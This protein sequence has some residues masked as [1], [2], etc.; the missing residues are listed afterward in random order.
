MATGKQIPCGPCSV[1][2]VI[3]NAW[4]WC[5]SCEEGICEDCEH[6]H[7]RSKSS[8]NHR[9]I[10]IE[11][12]SKIEHFS[13]SQICEQHGEN[14]E[15]FCKC[16][17]EVLCVVCVP[18]KHKA[19]SD[20]LPISANSANARQSS[21]LSDLEEKIE[22]NL[23]NVKQCIKNRESATKEIKRQELEVKTMIIETRQKLNG[24]LDKLQEKMLH[25]LRSTA[26]TCKSKYIKI[27]ENL[28]STE[29]MLTKLRQ[30]TEH[31]KQFSSDIQV[32]LGTRQVNKRII[33]KVESTK[34]EIGAAKD[35]E[36]KVSIDRLI[37]KLSIDVEEFGKLTVLESAVNLN[38]WDTKIDQAQIEINVP[39]TESISDIKPQ[40][41]NSFQMSSE[42]NL[43]V[44]SCLILPNGNLLIANST[45]NSNLKEYSYTGEHIRDIPISGWLND[46]VLID[47]DRI[48][49]TYTNTSFLEIRNNNTFNVEKKISLQKYCWGVSHADGKLYVVHGDSIQVLDLS[50]RQ[51]KTIKTASTSV[52]RIFASRDR[53]VYSDWE[54][55]TVHCRNLN[56]D[57]IWQFVNDSIKF[58]VGVKAD[59]SNNIYVVG[60]TSNNLTVIQHDGKDSRTLLT[61][62]DGLNRLNA[63]FFDKDK[64]TLLISTIGGKV[65]LY[66]L[67]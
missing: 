54:S 27:L 14:L 56:G 44:T 46:I 52:S 21:A 30:E 22:G 45:K 6:V 63:V 11:D 26:D 4:R 39:I 8:R 10:S 64:R 58:P 60:Y 23:C 61:E 13:I 1:D 12:Y 20:V 18:S 7:R 37:E 19:C 67:V 62:S 34:R 53:I 17:D 31:M 36:L 38:F 51:L 3:K 48:V 49:V 28:K 47:L 66:K 5:T 29:E 40:L 9:V 33:H 2:D 16:H 24:Q 59:N 57:E 43:N 15:W 55:N 32:F 50:G 35:Y 65:L 41:I 42:R 25:E